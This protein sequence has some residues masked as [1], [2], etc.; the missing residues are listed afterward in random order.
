MGRWKDKLKH[1]FAVDPPGPVEPTEEQK[2][3]VEWFCRQIVK[4]GLATPGL[5]G[6]EMSRPL[7]YVTAQTLHFF[8]PGVWAI[9]RQQRYEQYVA[10]SRF[11][12]QRGSVE[13][14][15]RRIEELEDGFNHQP[16]G[17]GDEAPPDTGEGD[18]DRARDKP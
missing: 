15:C 14:L 4:R 3:A 9:L 12:E 10:F 7:N 1:A 17:D 2:P 11:L 6:L 13:Y 18:D 5:I 16:S 8:G